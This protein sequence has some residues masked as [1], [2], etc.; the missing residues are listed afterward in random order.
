MWSSRY[1]YQQSIKWQEKAKE[2]SASVRQYEVQLKVLQSQ[3]RKL[4]ELDGHY[5]EKLN[6]AEQ[7]NTALRS[8]LARGH[9]RMLVSG[10]KA[11]SDRTSSSTRSLGHDGAI[12]LSADTG[13]RILSVREGIIRDQQKLMYLQSYIQQFCLRE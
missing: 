8:Q 7:E 12:E 13:Q 3:Q 4:A 2:A 1:Y 11:C 9:R 6:E 5:T 10:Q